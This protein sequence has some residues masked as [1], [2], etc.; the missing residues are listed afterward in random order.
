MSAGMGRFRARRARSGHLLR[1]L[2]A[3]VLVLIALLYY[4]PVRTY[5]DTR[6]TLA[7]RAAEV[8]SLRRERDALR[9]RLAVSTSTDALAREAR[10]L[11]FV[12]PGEQLFI[13][14]GIP[15]WRRLH[16]TLRERDRR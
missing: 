8:T 13:V 10:R 6:H 14:K 1:W 5:I 9:R 2:A 16:S 15:L 7:G 3:A 4:K 11:G 12:K